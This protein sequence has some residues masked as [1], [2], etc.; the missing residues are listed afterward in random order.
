MT[1]QPND[2]K[3][4]HGL[5]FTFNY[6][7]FGLGSDSVSTIFKLRMTLTFSYELLLKHLFL[8]N[9]LME[10]MCFNQEEPSLG[11]FSNFSVR[12]KLPYSLSIR[13]KVIAGC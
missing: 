3:K 1:E 11:Q 10:S 8:T 4:P 7:L 6:Q 5:D 9:N 2:Q 12:K 13:M